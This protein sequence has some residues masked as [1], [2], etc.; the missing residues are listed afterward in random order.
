MQIYEKCIALLSIGSYSFNNF[1]KKIISVG[2]INSLC[3][4]N[5]IL[6]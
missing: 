5:Y 1:Y 6:S 3:T 4:T 2:L